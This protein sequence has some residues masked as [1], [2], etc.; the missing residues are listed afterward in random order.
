MKINH[1][2]LNCDGKWFDVDLENEE[3][4][5]DNVS[6]STLVDYDEIINI[7]SEFIKIGYNDEEFRN[8][9]INKLYKDFENIVSTIA[10]KEV[11]EFKS[12]IDYEDYEDADI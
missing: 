11:E 3:Y 5:E 6:F 9:F 2:K 1:S 4:G 12:I 10:D 7:I 8:K